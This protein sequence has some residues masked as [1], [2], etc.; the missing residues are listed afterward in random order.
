MNEIT[1]EVHEL[2][3]KVINF[4]GEKND[5][6]YKQLD[7]WLT[8]TLLTLD[9]IESDGDEDIQEQRKEIVDRIHHSLDELDGLEGPQNAPNQTSFGLED[10]ENQNPLSESPKPGTSNQKSPRKR[11]S[12]K[13]FQTLYYMKESEDEEQDMVAQDIR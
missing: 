6:D 10:K 2:E 11:K 4:K 3:E 8:S 5:Q 9:A 7:E 12:K 13:G 1:C